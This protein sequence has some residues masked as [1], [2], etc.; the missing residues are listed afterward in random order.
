MHKLLTRMLALIT[1]AAYLTIGTVVTRFY[2][3]SVTEIDFSLS[4]FSKF[5]AEPI[6][7]IA[8]VDV[9]N[10]VIEFEKIVIQREVAK[11]P[12]ARIAKA[13]ILR[14]KKNVVTEIPHK[15]SFTALPFEEV[16]HL[17]E[18]KF[19]NELPITLA[20]NF[21]SFTYTEKNLVAEKLEEAQV[22]AD[23]VKTQMA[24][25]QEIEPEFFDY[26]KSENQ[27]GPIEPEKS[28][29]VE[30]GETEKLKA[31]EGS[32]ESFDYS[33]LNAEAKE[34][35]RNGLKSEEVSVNDLMSFNYVQAN[36]DIKDSTNVAQVM[37]S[38]NNPKA[39]STPVP[40]NEANK[41]LNSF[42]TTQNT[43]PVEMTI[44]ASGIDFSKIDTV[45]GFEVR[46][47]DSMQGIEDYG[48][49][50]V[51]FKALLA[52]PKMTRSVV[53]LKRGYTPTNTDLIL[54]TGN[55]QTAIPLI[56]EMKFN[57]LNQQENIEG[58]TGAVI[59]ELDD[60]T[61]LAQLDVPFKTVL[62]L[63]ADFKPTAKSDYRYLAFLG[64]KTG[65]SLLTY[66]KADGLKVNKI[67]HIHENE[68]TFDA[69]YYE[70]VINEK[71]QLF[72]DDL[73]SKDKSP[74]IIS[75]ES[76]KVFA[77]NDSA[78]KLNDNTYR[79][80]FDVGQLGGRKYIELNHQEEPVFVGFRENNQLDIPSE[81][82][83]RHILSRLDNSKLGNRCL[84][85][86]N[87][88][89]KTTNFEVGAESVNSSLITYAQVLET[90]GKFYDSLSDKSEKIIIMGENQSSEAYSQDGKVN[91]KIE[92]TDGSEQY[93]SSYCSP[94]TYLIEQL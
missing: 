20:A 17:S 81:N 58:S 25:N 18:V 71:F 29:V 13:P 61:E 1:F 66:V 69:N 16:I 7:K 39:L 57:E 44:Q 33:K 40:K 94:N 3:A 30:A 49:G 63:D 56:D 31:E 48:S 85:Q 10:P 42:V 89:K 46:F 79:L 47:Q 74:L 9:A 22:Q 43:Y 24:A 11:K 70:Q 82:F 23:E 62:K 32:I 51:N 55:T 67:I 21:K 83:M 41:E 52:Q 2:F 54:E 27:N 73:L 4:T 93:L 77:K 19:E 34:S 26:P 84:I 60:E 28:K 72:E 37:T 68:V 78:R 91:I 50:E 87:L 80:N 15:V 88:T 45:H 35:P 90:D 59:V 75:G 6:K 64:V 92:F 8:Q 12:V 53:V 14:I 36:Q 5:T 76:V 86:V 38:Q 65:N